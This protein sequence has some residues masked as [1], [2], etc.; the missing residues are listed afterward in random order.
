[1]R[2]AI[3]S[4][5]HANLEAF[6]SVLADIDTARIDSIICL[7]DTIGYGPNPESSVTL[8]REKAIPSVIG[9]H[10]K[11][12]IDFRFLRG[13]NPVARESLEKT[14]G[15]LSEDTLRFLDALDTSI[16]AYGCRFV[17]G[18]PLDSPMTYLFQVSDAKLRRT[19]AKMPERLCFVGHTHLLE[20]V[21][22]DGSIALVSELTRRTYPLNPDRSYIINYHQRRQ[23]GAAAG[24]RQQ[25]QVRHPG[26]Q[27]RKRGN[28]ICSLQYR[29]R[30]RE[31]HRQRAPQESCTA[32]VVEPMG[33]FARLSCLYR[34]SRGKLAERVEG[35]ARLP[36]G[37]WIR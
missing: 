18:F 8:L 12:I 7:G 4:D 27:R 2:I 11:A 30:C 15:M 14:S 34:A 6:E 25:C 17:H 37:P 23:C 35:W 22:W 32:A 26:H 24:R 9:N 5:I 16:V 1:M 19:F 20:C 33:P 31:N 3:I 29:C 28:P 13:F 36:V 10:E 21:E